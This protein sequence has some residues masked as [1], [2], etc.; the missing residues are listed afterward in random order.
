MVS[1]HFAFSMKNFHFFGILISSL[2]LTG[3]SSNAYFSAKVRRREES[4]RMHR[5]SE[6]SAEKAKCSDTINILAKP[7]K[8]NG[9][10][11]AKARIIPTLNVA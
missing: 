2:H 7:T 10:F 11:H 4:S 5:K 6:N 3:F 8:K 9:T 1:L